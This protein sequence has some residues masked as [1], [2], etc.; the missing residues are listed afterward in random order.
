MG[1]VYLAED[2]RL[3]R[4]V[5][6]KVLPAGSMDDP[7]ARKRL[8]REAQA[9]ARLDHPNICA[10]YEV[11]ED[12]GT[13]FIVMQYVEGDTLASRLR[14]GPLD[15]R[16]AITVATQDGGGSRRGP[17][18]RHHPPGHQA[19]EHH[20]RLPRA[21]EGD[22]LRAGE[23]DL[24]SGRARE[25]GGH[26]CTAHGAGRDRRHS[27]VHVAGAAEERAPRCAQRH[28]QLRRRAVRDGQRPSAL[29]RYEHGDDDCRRSDAGTAVPGRPLERCAGV[30]GPDRP[31]GAVEG[32]RAALPDDARRRVG[33]GRVRT[34][35]R[36]PRRRAARRPRPGNG[37]GDPA[38]VR[39]GPYASRRP[40]RGW[41]RPRQS[42]SGSSAA[43]RRPHDDR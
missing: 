25:P 41:S 7:Q 34:G 17:L 18:A 43:E 1:E 5:A 6:I 13:S 14:L 36:E 19:A 38:L 33:S 37:S 29:R 32:P 10:I 28:L 26:G 16:Q 30:A 11:S 15:L 31:Q 21:G 12:A 3:A 24:R 4:R 42:A 39:A 23:G 20:D 27:A 40:S 22:G 35:A 2:P 9:A 8:V